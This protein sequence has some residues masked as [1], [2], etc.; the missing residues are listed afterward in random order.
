MFRFGWLLLWLYA[1]LDWKDMLE[2][3]KLVLLLF[4]MFVPILPTFELRRE[5]VG[6]IPNG[7]DEEDIEE[8]SNEAIFNLLV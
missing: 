6:G 4:T 8:G 7:R 3:E 1:W 5:D 2:L